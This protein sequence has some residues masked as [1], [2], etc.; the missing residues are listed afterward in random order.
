MGNNNSKKDLNNAQPSPPKNSPAYHVGL[1][2]GLASIMYIHKWHD[3]TAKNKDLQFPCNGTYDITKLAYLRQMLHIKGK[4][5]RPIEWEAFYYWDSVLSEMRSTSS[6][7]SKVHKEILD[8]KNRVLQVKIEKSKQD[9]WRKNQLD[10]VGAFPCVSVKEEVKEE[11]EDQLLEEILTGCWGSNSPPPA[12]D[13]QP[14]ELTPSERMAAVTLVHRA[15]REE[16]AKINLEAVQDLASLTLMRET[17]VQAASESND[18]KRALIKKCRE[19]KITLPKLIDREWQQVYEDT[20]QDESFTVSQWHS[21]IWDLCSY[22]HHAAHDI[23]TIEQTMDGAQQLTQGHT[24]RRR[25]S[26]GNTPSSTPNSP[27]LFL[28]KDSIQCQ[29]LLQQLLDGSLT[30]ASFVTTQS[31]QYLEK[32]LSLVR[33]ELL[34]KAPQAHVAFA[35]QTNPQ[36]STGNKTALPAQYDWDVARFGFTDIDLASWDESKLQD[37][38][39]YAVTKLQ[40]WKQL[41]HTCAVIEVAKSLASGTPT[42]NTTASTIIMPLREVPHP[43]GVSD[44]AYVYVPWTRQ[45]INSFTRQFP[46][47]REEPRKWYTEL[48]RIAVLGG[49]LWRDLDTLFNI[50][51]P[52]DLWEDCKRKVQWPECEPARGDQGGPGKEIDGLYRKVVEHLKEKVPEDRVDWVKITNTRQEKDESV[53]SYFDRLL[54]VYQQNSGLKNP[55]SDALPALVTSFVQGLALPIRTHLQ[56]SF[57]C[58]Q[59]EPIDKILAAAR[60]C[61]DYQAN[62]QASESEKLKKEKVRLMVAQEQFYANNRGRERSRGRARGTGRQYTQTNRTPA[63][64]LRSASLPPQGTSCFYCKDPSHWKA[65]CPIL[66]KRNEDTRNIQNRGQ[67]RPQYTNFS[68]HTGYQNNEQQG[69]NP[70][71]QQQWTGGDGWVPVDSDWPPPPPQTSL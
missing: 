4:K 51:V 53:N 18:K 50:I 33:A 2:K 43:P 29:A 27:R 45:D 16:V 59:Q 40:Q 63:L 71:P 66:K 65:D 19:K 41:I 1:K 55:M 60:Y 64:P 62:A 37:T 61:S 48:E 70:Q 21:L 12:P 57:V 47:L 67:N 23:S 3:L 34:N 13:T 69:H 38:L 32:T 58:W 44:Q 30:V 56:T 68:Q 42:D 54:Q 20:S 52:K 46:K 17:A 39:D 24:D 35:K 8:I 11:P 14:T 28:K 15:L 22:V 9:N 6:I 26:V 10:V 7:K 31:R 5:I 49:L 25:G 36:A